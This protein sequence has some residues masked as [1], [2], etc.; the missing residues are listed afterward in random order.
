MLAAMPTKPL[1]LKDQLHTCHKA[2][3]FILHKTKVK[4]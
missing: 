2:G 4:K 1:P 3:V